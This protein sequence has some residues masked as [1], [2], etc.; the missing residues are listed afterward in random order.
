MRSRS[1]V[2]LAIAVAV[3][4][5]VAQAAESATDDPGEASFVQD[6]RESVRELGNRARAHAT[7]L[8]LRP[9]A[10][11]DPAAATSALRRQER[12]L[13]EVV[14]F[15]AGPEEIALPVA[16]RTAPPALPPGDDLE[17]RAA[18]EHRRATRLALRLGLEEPE[19][20]APAAG[21][22]R[23]REE[24]ARWT[25]VARWLADRT[26]RLTEEE[27]PM[28]ERVPYYDELTCIAEHESGGRW[29]VSTGNGY[30]GGLQMDRQFQQTYA[31]AVYEAK[32]TADNWTKEEQMHAAARAVEERGFTPWSTTA[33]MCGL[34]EFGLGG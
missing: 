34:L 26:E 20:L 10:V 9:A 13:R 25:T 7:R 6:L 32:G 28:S 30:H 21:P 16:R 12:R 29:D 18:Y 24:L 8:G 14:A 27:R 23:R 19:P 1:L 3:V 22:A 17:S 5:V 31:P 15:L 33:R 11:P 2:A 4:P